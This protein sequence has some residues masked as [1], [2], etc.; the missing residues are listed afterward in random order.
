MM[1][2]SWMLLSSVPLVEGPEDLQSGGPA[3]WWDALTDAQPVVQ[4]AA[5]GL[6]ALSLLLTVLTVLYWKATN[7]KRQRN[8]QKNDQKAATGATTF[9]L[10][11]TGSRKLPPR[12][13]PQSHSPA[14]IAPRNSLR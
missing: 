6:F 5:G 7:P 12:V 14:T 1:N 4:G 10:P 9:P 11:S 8:N 13:R 3:P 2:A